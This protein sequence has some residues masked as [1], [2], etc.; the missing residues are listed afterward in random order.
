M[1]SIEEC[2]NIGQGILSEFQDLEFVEST[3]IYTRNGIK[4]TSVSHMIENFCVGFDDVSG[5]ISYAEKRG[6]DS[7]DVLT[8]WRGENRLS[9]DFGHA[10][11]DFGERYAIAKYF[12]KTE[13]PRPSNLAE[14]AM[15][16]WYHDMIDEPG[17][18]YPIC[19]EARMYHKDYPMAGTADKLLIDRRDGECL[20]CDW[21]TNKD[22]FKRAYCNLLPPF[23][24][25][26]DNPYHHYCIQFSL[27][28][29]MLER[30]GVKVKQ[31]ILSYCKKDEKTGKLYQN[32]RT[33]DLTPQ[34]NNFL[35]TK[36]K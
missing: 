12:T 36:F 31:R 10:A 8:A 3:H 34:L 14:L 26:P 5:S 7:Q 9:T 2:L 30:I 29:T 25:F 4:Q 1:L 16:Q 32:Y 28:Q 13:L 24:K 11:H 18:L 20:V 27:Y 15:V 23:E 21:K 22:I 17:I 19:L 6:L 35:L 33:P